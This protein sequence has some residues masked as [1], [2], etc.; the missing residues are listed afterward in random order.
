[1][2]GLKSI[3]AF[4][5]R[6]GLQSMQ[7]ITRL[8]PFLCVLF[9]CPAFC[10]S[11]GE[12]AGD[13]VG[14]IANAL[15][16]R[17]FARALTLSQS[18]LSKRP[19]DFR[20]WTLRGMAAA[21]VGSRTAALSD[22][23][24]ALKL[25]PNY[26]PA[27]EGAAQT[28]F[29]MGRD[30]ARPLLE[31]VLIQRPDDATS[32]A[33]L[34]VLDYRKRNCADAIEH[35]QK[36]AGVIASQPGALSE[37]GA[38][39]GFLNRD[40]DA[41][42]VFAQA[43]ALDPA[44]REARYNLALAQ[45]DAHHADDALA[46]LQPLMDAMPADEDALNL[47]AEILEAKGDTPRATEVLRNAIVAD[48]KHL[49]SYLQFA[50]L[51]Y[52]HASP[53]VGIDMLNAGL[54]QLPNE[55]RLYLVRGILLTQLGEFTQ[56]AEDFDAASGIDPQLSFLGVAEGLVKSQQHKPA[57]ALKGFRADVETH[58]NGAYAHYLLAEE[59][60]EEGK[61]E[62]S[63]EYKEEVASAERAVKLDPTLVAAHDLLSTVY[64]ENG[65]TDLA[66]EQARA[67]LALDANDQQAVYHLIVAMRK[68]DRKDELP[69][70][71]KRLVD[72][73]SN[74]VTRQA[75][76]KRYRLSDD[77]TSTDSKAP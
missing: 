18:A 15:R 71:L 64:L 37:Y 12:G 68:T 42:T 60:L 3:P 45:W 31:R 57:E 65:H 39:L 17:D 38:C 63:P 28:E 75:T 35:F 19:G 7:R 51:S 48:P 32:H 58:P 34:G 40:E 46:T 56:A 22:Y 20:I 8:V 67:A 10:Q 36:A 26:L 27:L 14:Q 62:G 16:S 24:S 49:D 59:L 76:G 1:M 5:P 69:A 33:M 73:R 53:R 70:L 6:R 74:A 44:R 25:A 2:S 9:A 21:G 4:C 61:P 77:P 72:L 66:I 52:D 23:E 54:T 29:Q 55:P 41:V 43:L 47:G 50:M 30:A 11:Q 13:D